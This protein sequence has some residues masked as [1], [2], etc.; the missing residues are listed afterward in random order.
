MNDDAL[1]AK[2]DEILAEVRSLRALIEQPNLPPISE[3]A[4]DLVDAHY[5][6]ARLR[7]SVRTVRA[8]KAGTKALVRQSNR[9]ITY[10]RG[11]VDKFI[12]SRG[13]SLKTS[14]QR[15]LRLLNRNKGRRKSKE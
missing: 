9:P 3:R 12:R 1:K 5:V 6:A 2:L 4:D 7:L 10:L 14:A 15:G 11:D 13:E 8:G